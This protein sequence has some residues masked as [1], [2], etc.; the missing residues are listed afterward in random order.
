M[1][2]KIDKR[3]LYKLTPSKNYF[4]SL[5]SSIIYQ[6]IS[7][8]AGDSIYKKFLRMF[9]RKKPHP[10]AFLKF[11]EKKL[12]SAG[13]S[14][15]KI[16]YLRDLAQKFLDDTI[17]VKNLGKMSNENVKKH[18]IKI[19][20]VGSWTADMFLIFALNRPDILPVGDLGIQKG[21]Q[22]AFKLKKLPSENTMHRLAR[23]Y[24]GRRTLLTLHL[25]SIL[26]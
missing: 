12:K 7:T 25:W 11:S 18:L 24:I 1:N 16:S 6:Q 19:K 13:L 23:P 26:K 8:A 9:G 20:G 5:A 3:K 21:F 17:D 10:E 15:Q 2:I 14:Q 4:L 22:K